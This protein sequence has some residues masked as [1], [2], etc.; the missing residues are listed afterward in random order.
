MSRHPPDLGGHS[1]H[2][3]ST[4]KRSTRD[5]SPAICPRGWA[6]LEQFFE[7]LRPIVNIFHYFERASLHKIQGAFPKR[8]PY[9]NSTWKSLVEL[10]FGQ[11][12]G[13][14]MQCPHCRVEV[15][16][17]L[18]DTWIY[19]FDAH[20]VARSTKGLI[21]NFKIG[22]MECPACEKAILQLEVRPL[23]AKG[24]GPF[25]IYPRE[26]S[27]P[28]ARPEVPDDLAED[29][30]EAGAVLDLSP[31]ASAALS[32]RCLQGILRQNGYPQYDL[33]KAIE[34]ILADNKLP[35]WLAGNLDSIRTV[36]NFAAHPAKDK[37]TG[38]ILPVEEHEAEWNL[39]V[40]EALF[41]FFYVAPAKD[42]IK[43]DAL[44]AKLLAAGKKPMQ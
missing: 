1:I 33:A 4:L 25:L 34:A 38:E 26:R 37:H 8:D 6:V 2:S 10:A 20:L 15:H 35:S 42:A 40:L 7:G 39:D 31:K 41:D 29:F 19:K 28:T 21:S 13:G 36:G 44:N 14:T 27:R 22:S 43:R 11:S 16:E 32:R 3:H 12:I 18:Y 5:P 24:P 23:N 30:N 9:K 17:D